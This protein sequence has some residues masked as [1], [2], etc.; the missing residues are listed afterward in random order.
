MLVDK[1]S[2]RLRSWNHFT[3]EPRPIVFIKIVG[4]FNTANEIFHC[5]HFECPSQ[6]QSTIS[7]T[8]AAPP[9]TA[10]AKVP[11]PNDN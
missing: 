4:T 7:T 8:D 11:S 5:V 2:E 6:L 10:K 3:F 9:K 1:R